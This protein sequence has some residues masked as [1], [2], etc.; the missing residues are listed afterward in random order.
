MIPVQKAANNMKI[1]F[2]NDVWSIVEFAHH[3]PGKGGAV[4]RLKIKSLTTGR[5]L[6]ETLNASEKID[7]VEVAYRKM[8]YL[9]HD[10]DHYVFMDNQTYE[11]VQV[12]EEM[13]DDKARFLIENLE[14]TIVLWDDKII[15]V[16]L[17]A[18]VDLKVVETMNAERGNTATNVTKDAKLESGFV[19]QV[20]LFINTGDVVRIDTRDGAYESRV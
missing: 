16:D 9:Y 8:A 17:P 5:V 18:K 1:Q 12:S 19:A 10:G 3:K 6:E 14:V 7:Q 15:G 20:P 11:Q 2:K 4:V 13:M